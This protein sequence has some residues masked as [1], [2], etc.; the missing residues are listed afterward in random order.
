MGQP[1]GK[2]VTAQH[3]PRIGSL[4]TGVGGLDLAVTG[5]TDG[6]LAWAS[7]IDPA[8]CRVLAHRFPGI[9]NLGD[10]TRIDW[11]LVEPI[12]VLCGGTPCQ[13]LSVAGRRAGLAPGTRS[14][15][16]AGMR[17]V[18]AALR[19]AYIV[20]ENVRGALSAAADSRLEPCPGCVGDS[21]HRKPALRALGR[22][23][24]DLANLGYDAR[25]HGLY[26]SDAGAPHPRYRV[27]LLGVARDTGCE[28]WVSWRAAAAAQAQTRRASGDI[29]GPGGLFAAHAA[30]G[31]DL[32]LLPTPSACMANDG[33]SIDSWEARRRRVRDSA[34]NGNGMGT[35]LAI[36]VQHPEWGKY[37][38]AIHR[39]ERI[40][41]RRAPA[42]IQPG[43]TGT[44]RLSARFAEWMMGLSD[45]W[46]T[47]IPGIT[48]T[49]ALRLL[50][51]SVVP[52]QAHQA[53][54]HITT[55]ETTP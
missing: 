21:G 8:A 5:F 22:V 10:I 40:L 17:E 16:W 42:P 53:L 14:N 44:P 24:G 6:R 35:P 46:V 43:R 48:R 54:H 34:R 28:Q 38:A 2:P 41:G 15:L 55:R 32:T 33:E 29:A 27:F 3:G 37:T 31:P 11:A 39:W 45:G 23:L 30:S 49:A 1:E 50:G 25:W 12:D 47:D 20:W 13:D 9:P 26:A 36:A 51:N 7:D 18:I 19:P 52:Q 4:F